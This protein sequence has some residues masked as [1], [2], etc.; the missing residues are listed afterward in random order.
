MQLVDETSS[1]DRMQFVAL[2]ATTPEHPSDLGVS[3]CTVS[4]KLSA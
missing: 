4:F 1:T 3:I 2:V